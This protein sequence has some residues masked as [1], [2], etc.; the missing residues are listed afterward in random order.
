MEKEA[1][2][3]LVWLAVGPAAPAALVV[4]D[5]GEEAAP[6]VVDERE[7]PLCEIKPA[8]L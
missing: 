8:Q 5:I 6:M 1:A 7:S 4:L 2:V 3:Q